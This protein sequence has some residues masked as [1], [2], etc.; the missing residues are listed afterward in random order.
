MVKVIIT[1][2][3]PLAPVKTI[4]SAPIDH[5]VQ[6][7]TLSGG[8]IKDQFHAASISGGRHTSDGIPTDFDIRVVELDL[9]STVVR[10]YCRTYRFNVGF[11]VEINVNL[12]EDVITQANEAGALIF[13]KDRK[14]T[15]ANSDSRVCSW[16]GSDTP[17]IGPLCIHCCGNWHTT[18]LAL[19]QWIPVVGIPFAIARTTLTVG[20]AVKLGRDV[21]DAVLDVVFTTIDIALSPFVIQSIV[22]NVAA[23]GADPAL[24]KVVAVVQNILFQPWANAADTAIEGVEMLKNVCKWRKILSGK[25]RAAISKVLGSPRDRECQSLVQGTEFIQAYVCRC[26]CCTKNREYPSVV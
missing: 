5:I 14:G 6:I 2:S 12:Q 19:V 13:A 26:A 17:N 3:S 18:W 25:I 23:L 11:G 22:K 16:C 24:K 9:A 8:I 15:Y 10:Y 20:R 1:S 4:D 21:A 7:T